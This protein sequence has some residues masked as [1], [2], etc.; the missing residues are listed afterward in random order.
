MSINNDSSY[1]G[2]RPNF[3]NKPVLYADCYVDL[4]SV[5]EKLPDIFLYF[6]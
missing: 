4:D 2:V 3:N 5:R 6:F 1:S